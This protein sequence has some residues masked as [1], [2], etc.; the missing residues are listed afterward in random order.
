MSKKTA[1][2]VFSIF[3]CFV[4]AYAQN[5]SELSEKQKALIHMK[6]SIVKIFMTQQ[7]PNFYNPWTHIAPSSHTGSGAIITVNGKKRIITN[8]HVVT[9]QTYLQVKRQGMPEK[10]EAKLEFVA[11]DG[12]L[13][14]LSVLDEKF[15][16]GAE[17][18][19]L[20]EVPHQ[21]RR[22]K[23][24]GFPVFGDHLSISEGIVSRI[25]YS[26]YIHVR[27]QNLV[28][29]TD[30]AIN[31]GNSGGPAI[32]DGKIVGV[33]FQNTPNA[34]GLND[35]IPANLVRRFL[36]D[37][38]DGKY[39]GIPA[40]NIET[41]IMESKF[42]RRFCKLPENE[43]GVMVKRVV[44][45]SEGSKFKPKD[46]L[47]KIGDFDIAN[48]GTVVFREGERVYY[49]YAVSLYQMD[50]PINIE[51]YRNGKKQI[52]RIK[53]EPSKEHVRGPLYETLPSYYI[54]GGL[55]FTDLTEN[56]MD[57]WPKRPPTS[58]EKERALLPSVKRKH[59][60]AL[61]RV[62]AHQI[63]E[64][65]QDTINEIVIR[66]NNRNLSEFKDVIKAFRHPI[67]GKYHEIVLEGEEVIILPVKGL[68]KA[69][70]EIQGIYN[71]P[72]DRSPDA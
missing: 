71:Y 42:L 68:K 30:A 37:I 62:L 31:A 49:R 40:L 13:A 7:T 52:I 64:G 51:I 41:Q 72:K 27:R 56:Y 46:V 69:N 39:H 50:K 54:N 24:Y 11:H 44:E 34:E 6:K 43:S 10:F 2:F 70:K 3:I 28:I 33:A 9:N 12:E 16:E 5:I 14:L 32:I 65:F 38:K 18:L 58:Y 23:I 57:L 59:V 15:F 67:N 66:I 20:G 35:L 19:E 26:E 61:L 48:D 29:Q 55:V 45:D 25:E 36:A 8:A 22:V 47:T 63:N 53:A 4:T 21:E 17:T 1:V 60:V